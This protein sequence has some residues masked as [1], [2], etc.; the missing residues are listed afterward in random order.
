MFPRRSLLEKVQTIKITI[1]AIITTTKMIFAKA[2]TWQ[3]PRAQT[4]TKKIN[5]K[6]KHKPAPE[7]KIRLVTHD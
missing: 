3:P 2:M 5:I 7:S 1:I 4:E 6:I